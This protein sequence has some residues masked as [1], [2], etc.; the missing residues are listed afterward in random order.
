[1]LHRSINKPVRTNKQRSM[2]SCAAAQGNAP[3]LWVV[4]VGIEPSSLMLPPV[5]DSSVS[6]AVSQQRSNTHRLVSLL[7]PDKSPGTVIHCPKPERTRPLY[8]VR[9]ALKRDAT[10]EPGRGGEG[11]CEGR[12]GLRNRAADRTKA[13]MRPEEGVV[14]VLSQ[15]TRT[16][17]AQET[18]G[19]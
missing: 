16:Q 17:K 19:F 3:P 1:M 14:V 8:A 10:S 4:S 6:S 7:H 15:S 12:R 2:Y 11:G 9:G 18:K 5:S 13:T